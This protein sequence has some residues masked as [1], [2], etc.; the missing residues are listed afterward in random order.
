M[1]VK[2]NISEL[3]F[4]TVSKFQSSRIFWLLLIGINLLICR[5]LQAGLGD[6]PVGARSLAMAGTYVALANTADA[7][8]LN[9]GGL[10][11]I[12]GT[13]ISLFYQK[14]FGLDDVNIGSV[15]ASFPLWRTRLNLGLLSLGNSLYQEQVF[16]IA[17]SKSYQERIY[18][19]IGLKYQSVEIAGYG[20]DGTLGIDIGWVV[21]IHQQLSLGFA[22]KNINRP[23][24]GKSREKLPQTFS[25]GLALYPHPRM[26]LN[27]EIFKDVRFEQ[28]IRFGVEFK[29]FDNLALRTGTANNPSRF[30]A[31]FGIRVNRFTVDYAFFTHNDL[32]LTQQMSFSIHFGRKREEGKKAK[33]PVIAEVPKK[34]MD[35]SLETQSDSVTVTQG[36]NIN[37]ASHEELKKLPGIGEKLASLIIEYREKNGP[38]LE[39]RD[40]LNIRRIGMKTFEKIKAQIVVRDIANK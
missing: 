3:E 6:F 28:E 39:T 13:E 24:I 35:L 30:S 31:G 37:T 15:S 4:Q 1:I 2:R 5:N 7:L 33:K 32:G 8:F 36:I 26:I 40:L 29:A 9:P 21:A 17:Y 18:C 11:Q 14:P 20:S 34:S 27:L 12:T 38:F 22:A 25:T 10:S 23:S 19:G 16:L